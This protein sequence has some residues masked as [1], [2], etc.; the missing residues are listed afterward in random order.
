MYTDLVQ[1][2]AI[3][4]AF[5]GA[6]FAIYFALNSSRIK[7]AKKLM[8]AN[9]IRLWLAALTSP[10][11]SALAIVLAKITDRDLG[12]GVGENNFSRWIV[13]AAIMLTVIQLTRMIYIFFQLAMIEVEE[14][15][16]TR[17]ISDREIKIKRDHV[18]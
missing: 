5:G 8:G 15:V 12:K 13:V 1:V 2:T 11:F 4:A 17:R 18:S 16:T 10:W 7:H 14:D 3:F 6:T 9:L